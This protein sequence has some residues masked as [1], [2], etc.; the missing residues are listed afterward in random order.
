MTDP[1]DQFAT[2][3]RRVVGGAAGATAAR[4]AAAAATGI[5]EACPGQADSPPERMLYPLKEVRQR[6]SIRRSM[7]V[8]GWWATANFLV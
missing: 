3:I 5:A 1:A 7:V 2:A 4:T 8:S 6:L